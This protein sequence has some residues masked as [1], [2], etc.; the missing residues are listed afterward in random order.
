[1]RARGLVVF[2]LLAGLALV[3]VAWPA[4]AEQLRGTSG[5]GFTIT[6]QNASG[7]IVSRIDPGTYE[8]VARDT[9]IDHNFHIYGPGVEESTSVD[10]VETVTWTVTFREGRY[11]Y[12]CD[13]HPTQMVKELVVG[14][15]PAPP[16]PPPPPP[17]PLPKLLATV[18]PKATISL[19]SATGA[20]L[21]NGVKARTYAIV[22][23]DRSKVHN[24]HLVGKG[25]NRRSTLA[26]ATTTTWK[27]KLSA[28]VLRFYSDKAPKT[29]KGS[30]RVRL[31]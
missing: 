24:F 27:V 12:L 17:P 13:L 25:V 21:R 5:P 30:I 29:V 8:L 23:R 28:G 14:N 18:G 26:G 9:S 19:R 2:T 3:P 10:A 4:A 6:L 11:T 7:T 16:P 1:M 31:P 20:V 15:P 22:V